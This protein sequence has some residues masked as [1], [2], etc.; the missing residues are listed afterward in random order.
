[1]SMKTRADQNKLSPALAGVSCHT[2]CPRPTPSSAGLYFYKEKSKLKIYISKIKIGNDRRKIDKTKVQE[3]AKSIKQNG[4]INAITVGRDNFLIAGL[5]RLEACK[6]LGWDKIECVVEDCIHNTDQFKLLEI[7]ENLIRSELDYITR[8]DLSV[9]RDEILERLG[10]RAK[11]GDNQFGGGAENSP[12][13]PV[14]TTAELAKE[15]GV[16]ERT[17]QVEKQISKALSPES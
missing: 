4:L 12:P 14:K 13:P 11:R 3:L 2:N 9:E 7:D 5:H 16:S 17:L 10:L 1:M 6:L 15:A 8:G